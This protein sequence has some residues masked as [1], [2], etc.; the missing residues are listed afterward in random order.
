M[1][2]Y[3]KRLFAYNSWA[4]KRLLAAFDE[5]NI[6]DHE[7]LGALSHFLAAQ[8][9]WACRVMQSTSTYPLWEV[10]D[11]V[12]CQGLAMES[13]ARWAKI[14][15]DPNFDAAA[16]IDYAN[17]KGEKFQTSLADI[18]AH[19]ANHSTYHRAQIARIIRILGHKVPA[20]DFI[21]FS[22]L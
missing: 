6:N 3:L 21:T 13:E 1:Q 20:T 22:R 19:V 11:F 14:L 12:T 2:A 7:A 9:I 8:D 17:M 18:M 4:N 10:L 5:Q 15:N 16:I